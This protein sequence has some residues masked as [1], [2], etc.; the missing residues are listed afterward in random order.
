MPL[1]EHIYSKGKRDYWERLDADIRA[2]AAANGLE[3]VRD[4]DSMHR[5]FLAPPVIVNFFYHE[6]IKKSAKKS[7]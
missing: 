1:Y 7:G 6:E 3:Y 2:Y 5:P 4:D